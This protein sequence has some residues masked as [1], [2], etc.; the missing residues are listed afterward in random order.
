MWGARAGHDDDIVCRTYPDAELLFKL[1]VSTAETPSL[2][3]E[4]YLLLSMKPRSAL[5]Y[6]LVESVECSRGR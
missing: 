5:L 1:Y 3:T 4:N 2:S 6:S